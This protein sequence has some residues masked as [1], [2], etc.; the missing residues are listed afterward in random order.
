[1]KKQSTVHGR[2]STESQST[3]HAHSQAF[4]FENT[5]EIKWSAVDGGQWTVDYGLAYTL[6][7][8][9]HTEL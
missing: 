8:K 5:L 4:K 1:M 6:I 2:Q 3:V 7:K 9:K